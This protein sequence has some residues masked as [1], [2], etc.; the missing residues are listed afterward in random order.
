MKKNNPKN[1]NNRKTEKN[2]LAKDDNENFWKKPKRKP[3]TAK[4]ITLGFLEFLFDVAGGLAEIP[5][6][7][8]HPQPFNSNYSV[9]N[10]SNLVYQCKRNGYIKIKNSNN[11]NSIVLTNKAQLKI[12]DKIVKNQKSDGKFRFISYDIPENLRVARDQFRR[13][14][15]K[16]GFVQIQ[17]SLWV[18]NKNVSQLVEL[19]AYE[20]KVEK[21]VAYIVSEKS[22]ID[23]LIQKKLKNIQANPKKA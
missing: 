14:I 3:I 19:A 17:K 20:Y 21:Y 16:L 4:S 2:I 6:H 5:F 10:F 7:G 11:Q 22:D 18:C 15:K 8:R 9:S 23:G 12:I 13:T 1:V